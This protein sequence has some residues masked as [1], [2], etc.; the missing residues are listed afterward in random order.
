MKL[1]EELFAKCRMLNRSP[2]TAS[3]YWTWIEQFLRSILRSVVIGCIR[4]TWRS[5]ILKRS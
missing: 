4:A 2:N 1:K 3:A 5:R